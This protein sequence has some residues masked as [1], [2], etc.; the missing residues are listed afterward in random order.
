MQDNLTH[1]ALDSDN[2]S[3]EHL[4]KS[5][6]GSVKSLRLVDQSLSKTCIN[7]L[8]ASLRLSCLT[9]LSINFCY[10][11]FKACQLLARGLQANHSLVKLSLANNAL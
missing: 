10:P 2:T 11:S 1:L 6:P 9:Q 3:N 4:L 7:H 5:M 8:A